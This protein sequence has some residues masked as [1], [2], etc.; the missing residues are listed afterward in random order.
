[1]SETTTATVKKGLSASAQL[2]IV[3]AMLVSFLGG[4]VLLVLNLLKA[5]PTE[6][7]V[8]VIFFTVI[9]LILFFIGK[10]GAPKR[11]KAPKRR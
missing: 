1:M 11:P 10:A 3:V 8:A 6:W 2:G 7:W 5:F 9:P 4:A